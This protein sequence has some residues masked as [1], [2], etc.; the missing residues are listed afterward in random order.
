MHNIYLAW[1]VDETADY[2]TG[3][4]SLRLQSEFRQAKK[5]MREEQ[6]PSVRRQTECEASRHTEY[7]SKERFIGGCWRPM[8][9][10]ATLLEYD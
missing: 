9:F 5:P 2:Q 6:M 10:V 8:H 3:G 4:G 1:M 7:K